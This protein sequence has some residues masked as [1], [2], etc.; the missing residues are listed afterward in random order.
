MNEDF[1]IVIPTLNSE[2]FLGKTLES[3]KKQNKSIKIECIF[4]DGGSSDDTLSIINNFNQTNI[5]KIILYNQVGLSNALNSGF[6]VASG[7]YF[8]YLNS[9]DMLA[10]NALYSVKKKFEINK[11]Y[12]WIIGLSENIGTKYFLNKLVS[13]YKRTLFKLINFNLLCTNNII[14][15]PSVYWKNSFFQNIG[16][17]NE[18]LNY[19]MDYDMWLR[20]IKISQPLKFKNKLSYFRRHDESLSHKNL[21][22]QFSEKFKTMR[23]YNK[24][25][26]ICVLHLFL[27]LIIVFIYKITNY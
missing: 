10:D 1:S 15:Q 5:S 6:K 25:V 12:Q 18:K 16:Y 26:I 19:N 3:I 23:K 2:K 21:I 13:N 7:K 24:N 22:K 8:S 27:S 11:N 9:D 4:S 14:S 20:M 17:F